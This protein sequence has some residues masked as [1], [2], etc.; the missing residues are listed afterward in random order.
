MNLLNKN[1]SKRKKLLEIARQFQ[2]RGDAVDKRMAAT[3]I[4]DYYKSLLYDAGVTLGERNFESYSIKNRKRMLATRIPAIGAMKVFNEIDNIRQKT[5]HQDNYRIRKTQL[6]EIIDKAESIEDEM[7]RHIS[8][9]MKK[10]KDVKD[11]MDPLR[12]EL[13][14]GADTLR[15]LT[16][17]LHKTGYASDF[18]R[19]SLEHSERCRELSDRMG[20]AIER[21]HIDA[22]VELKIRIRDMIDMIDD[23]EKYHQALAEDQAYADY[24]A[25]R[26]GW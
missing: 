5:E 6:S 25:Q 23:V 16:D 12:E 7:K 14:T 3:A 10:R 21:K 4:T 24:K 19:K 17:E 9:Y 26:D 22:L 8:D 2:E 1:R 15:S 20:D 11:D 18:T 13:S